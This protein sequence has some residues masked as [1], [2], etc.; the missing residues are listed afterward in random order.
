MKLKL[1]LYSFLTSLLVFTL[2]AAPLKPAGV[3][4]IRNMMELSQ[5]TSLYLAGGNQ[6]AG[7]AAALVSGMLM[8]SPQLSSLDLSKPITMYLFFAEPGIQPVLFGTPRQGISPINIPFQPG[9][10]LIP[11]MRNG[12]VVYA[13]KSFQPQAMQLKENEVKLP[14]GIV[15]G[16][17]FFRGQLPLPNQSSPDNEIAGMMSNELSKISVSLDYPRKNLVNIS[18]EIEAYRDSNLA[19]FSNSPHPV[20]KD[21]VS[22]L[23]KS[24]GYIYAEVPKN[25]TFAHGLSI[26]CAAIS[27]EFSDHEHIYGKF[28]NSIVS[29]ERD[30]ALAFS[31]RGSYFLFSGILPTEQIKKD[32]EAFLKERG[33]SNDH[34]IYVF[35]N[36]NGTDVFVKVTG[37]IAN[38]LIKVKDNS[39]QDISRLLNITEK[40][41]LPLSGRE[42]LAGMFRKTDGTYEKMI[43]GTMGNGKFRINMNLHP[44]EIMPFLPEQ[45]T[46][47]LHNP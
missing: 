7:S 10:I 42:F 2:S 16:V 40:I 5:K 41:R 4:T 37:N 35:R 23:P 36:D 29:E 6:Q 11:K 39:H 9:Q 45:F 14:E 26:F 20:L 44:M 19:S 34:K 22:I 46:G 24:E 15:S 30:S 43:T 47:E 3:F 33:A 21:R 1:T 25:R 13:T 17:Y 32:F 38:L 27:P 28:L 12:K 18:M 31:R 8:M